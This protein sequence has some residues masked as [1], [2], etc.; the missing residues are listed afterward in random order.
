MFGKINGP[1]ES[2][3]QLIRIDER[4]FWLIINNAV[5]ARC[6]GDFQIYRRSL[7]R[8]IFPIELTHILKFE[9]RVHVNR[10][11]YTQSKKMD[12]ITNITNEPS[13]DD[14]AADL[15][16]LETIDYILTMTK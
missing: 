11:S 8:K 9:T 10:Q 13:S 2:S 4:C 3:C 14:T 15:I 5:P 6:L 12:A 7:C 16:I 1:A